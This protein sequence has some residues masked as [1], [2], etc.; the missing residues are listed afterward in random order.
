AVTFF[1]TAIAAMIL[2]WRKKQ[3]YQNS[4]IAR[5]KVA[6]IPLVTISGFV[7]AL[8]LGWNL[9][10][11]LWPPASK[12]NL[13]GINNKESLIFMGS[14]YALAIIIYVV[15]KLYR[16]RQGIDLKAVYQEIPVD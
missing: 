9:Y 11:W 5:Y 1:G 13:Y 16:K 2:P 3:L 12:G 8:F 15:A 10:K 4:A 7:T 6:G 14:M